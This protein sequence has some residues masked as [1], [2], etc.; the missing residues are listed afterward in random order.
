VAALRTVSTEHHAQ[1]FLPLQSSDPVAMSDAGNIFQRDD[2]I[3]VELEFARR[4]TVFALQQLV[5]RHQLPNVKLEH[6]VQLVVLQ[7]SSHPIKTQERGPDPHSLHVQPIIMRHGSCKGADKRMRPSMVR[8]GAVRRSWF[9]R[10]AGNCYVCVDRSNVVPKTLVVW[11]HVQWTLCQ[12]CSEWHHV[13]PTRCHWSPRWHHVQWTWCLKCE[14][15][16]NGLFT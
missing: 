16:H 2:G 1:K 9:T 3:G 12:W 6:F 4:L 7:M 14:P 5:G 15:W 13:E 10:L 8:K 11:H